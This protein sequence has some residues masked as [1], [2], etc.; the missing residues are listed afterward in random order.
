MPLEAAFSSTAG[1][2]CAWFC[3]GST[4][5]VEV[6][7]HARPDIVVIDRQHGLWE[8]LAMEAAIGI[9]RPFTPVIVRSADN[10]AG[11]IGEALDAGAVS[12]MVPLIESADAARRAVA[13]G[14]YPPAGERSAGGIR[15]LLVGLEGMAN[16]IMPATIGV[17]IETV[18]GVEAI[19]SIAAVPGLGYL[20][21]GT[22]DLRLSRG[23]LALEAIEAD[24]DRVLKAARANHL[25]CGIFTGTTQTALQQRAKGFDMVVA[26]SDIAIAQDGF[27]AATGA[28]RCAASA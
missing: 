9:A 25:P 2:S 16:H 23:D 15:P 8:R 14:R 11:A 4:A 17:M 5:L 22:G 7:L 26:Y 3:L 24:C 28:L 27:E 1:V 21:I 19:E 18:K 6:G 10:T 12:V 13:Y 20:F